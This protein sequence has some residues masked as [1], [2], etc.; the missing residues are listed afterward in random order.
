MFKRLFLIA[1][2]LVPAVAVAEDEGH[3]RTSYLFYDGYNGSQV[4]PFNDKGACDKAV[5]KLR[6]ANQ[7]KI[8]KIIDCW[9]TDA[10]YVVVHENWN[11]RWRKRHP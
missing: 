2:L 4:G 8:D 7:N 1:A 9:I 5:A 10:S 6:D 11:T 3:S